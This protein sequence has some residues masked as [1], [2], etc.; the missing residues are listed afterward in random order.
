M[1]SSVPCVSHS[2]SKTHRGV[3][4]FS[5]HGNDRG[6]RRQNRITQGLLAPR[7]GMVYHQLHSIGHQVCSQNKV[8]ES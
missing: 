7:L 8:E 6:V 5:S 2:L 1:G 4:V 3:L